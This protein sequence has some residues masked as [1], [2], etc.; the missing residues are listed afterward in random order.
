MVVSGAQQTKL[1]GALSVKE[2]RGYEP[3][4]ANQPRNKNGRKRHLIYLI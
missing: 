1:V 4:I 2:G 3:Q